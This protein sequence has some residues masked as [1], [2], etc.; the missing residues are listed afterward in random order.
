MALLL[1]GTCLNQRSI[2]LLNIVI[3][4]MYVTIALNPSLLLYWG[5]I[6]M[7]SGLI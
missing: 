4:Y 3:K 5:K 1:L 7:K 6:S 2:I